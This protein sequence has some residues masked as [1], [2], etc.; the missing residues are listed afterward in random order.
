[1]SPR[2]FRSWSR[3]YRRIMTS[4][5]VDLGTARRKMSTKL[6]RLS[7][8]RRLWGRR[9][10][11]DEFDNSGLGRKRMNIPGFTAERSIFVLTHQHFTAFTLTESGRVNR[12]VPAVPVMYCKT[13]C[14]WE[15]CGSALPGYP[16]PRCYICRDKCWFHE[17]GPYRL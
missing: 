9:R 1:M 7:G 13:E 3:K 15:V 16:V 2:N 8:A 4:R 10:L 5:T 6:L 14:A 17:S 11:T 12:I